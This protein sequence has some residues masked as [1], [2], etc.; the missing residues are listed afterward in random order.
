LGL[1]ARSQALVAGDGDA[2]SRF[3]ESIARLAT[4]TVRTDLARA[5]LL[6]GEWLRRQR[7]RQAARTELRAA[8]DMFTAMGAQAFAERARLELAATGERA[9][10]RSVDTLSELTPQESQV[11]RL[12]SDGAT[13]REIAAAMFISATTVEY[14]LSKVYRKA[15]HQIARVSPCR[16][17]IMTPR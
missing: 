7:R 14:H 15:R 5:H 2:E 1:L 10:R 11:A 8:H 13:N 6:Y 3:R 12:A 16:P 4:T 9:R 17:R